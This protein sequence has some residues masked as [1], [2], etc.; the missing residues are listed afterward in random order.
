MKR[1]IL[2]PADYRDMPWKNG[3]GV[4]CEIWREPADVAKDF[5]WRVSVADVKENGPFSFFQGYTRLINTLEGKGMRLTVDGQKSGDLKQYEPFAFSGDSR[6][7]SELIDGPIRDFNLIYRAG[8]H[9][10]RLEWLNLSA[11]RSFASQADW[12]LMY[13]VRGLE[14]RAA[15]SSVELEGGHT[16]LLTNEEAR[17]EVV[18]LAPAPG[19]AAGEKC[20]CLIE[21]TKEARP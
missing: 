5:D 12:I 4:T 9:R 21:I 1:T 2:G 14:I 13:A 15:G 7:E 16:L 20:C 19:A 8:A 17:P 11:P 18:T 3:L 10:A 6:V